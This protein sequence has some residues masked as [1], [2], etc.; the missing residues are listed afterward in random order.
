MAK[1]SVVGT[2]TPGGRSGWLWD[3]AL[4]FASTE[5]A[6]VER[7]AAALRESGVRCFF[8]AEQ[9]TDLWGKHLVE[10]LP[11]VYAEQA[12]AVVV[13]ISAQYAARDWT[14]LERRSALNRALIERR[15][16]VLPA[17]FDDTRLPGVLS[18]LVAVDLRP[19]SPERFAAMVLDKLVRLGVVASDAGPVGR[20]DIATAV[21]PPPWVTAVR[22]AEADPRRLGVHASIQVDGVRN[23]DQP[24]YVERDVDGGEHGVRA[25]VA[26]AARR[27]GFVLLVGGSSVGK[28]RCAYEAVRAVLPDWWLIH[29]SDAEEVATL[30]TNPPQRTVVW[31]DEIQRYLAGE[32][33]VS[34]GIMRA[35]LGA[36]SPVVVVGTMWPDRF[37]ALTE[38]PAPGGSDPYATERK[39]LELADAVT[40][41]PT[42][43]AAEQQRA[44]A[45][46]R[47]DRRLAVA[48]G[49]KDYGI[50]QTLA[51]AP[52]LI[53][54][55]EIAKTA[56]PYAWA[57][58]T[59]ALD[60]SRLGAQSALAEALLRHAAPGYCT[61]QQ[62]A[63]APASWFEQ[64]L[65]Y[66][67]RKLHG[68]AAALTPVGGTEMGQ[69]VGYTVADYLLQHAIRVRAAERVPT[70]AWDAMLAHL[71]DPDDALRVA[72]CASARLLYR[73][74]IPLYRRAADAGNRKARDQWIAHVGDLSGIAE[75][76]A[77][78]E[79][80]DDLF[81]SDTAKSL[82]DALVRLGE[83]DQLGEL[84]RQLDA[85][86]GPGWAL[87]HRLAQVLADRGADEE[88]RALADRGNY[89]AAQQLAAVLASRS[90]VDELRARARIEASIVAPTGDNQESW[91]RRSKREQTAARERLATFLARRNDVAELAARTDAPATRRLFTL[92]R[93]RGDMARLRRLADVRFDYVRTDLV[94]LL[95]HQGDIDELMSIASRGDKHLPDRLRL[96]FLH[97]DALDEFQALAKCKNTDSEFLATAL[98][99]RGEIARLT[100]FA[101]GDEIDTRPRLRA[102]PSTRQPRRPGGASCIPARRHWRHGEATI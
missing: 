47:A 25:L 44:E 20:A 49:V 15:V 96:V 81:V 19:L 13:F 90:D 83:L 85:D 32:R 1:C 72:D 89:V 82:A 42:F 21:E 91:S 58:L 92:L 39:V 69:T 77:R 54:H 40:V 66:T 12:A 46:A 9:Q 55:W 52:Q 84:C 80:D 57:V 41:A 38:V 34:G 76:K 60:V 8:D 78:A 51:A 62:R 28:T 36:S 86:H 14:R 16:Y 95:A 70:S 48:L 45:A 94:D 88:L 17:R 100:E 26:R 24:R 97:R 98:A 59:A 71:G 102:D 93:N 56:H 53:R 18:D 87:S 79:R 5:R 23:D 3:V 27:G 37:L 64:G 63:E 4:S 2:G 68:A 31:L 30:S 74:A 73:Y 7:V 35:L 29:P 10:E 43:G 101:A 11:S 65:A 50:P 33:G 75:L 61:D 99:D 6:Y 22:V 67:T